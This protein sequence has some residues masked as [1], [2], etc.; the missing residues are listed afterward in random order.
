MQSLGNLQAQ[1]SEFE[2]A[3]LSYF[4]AIAAFNSALLLAPDYNYA[5]HNKGNTLKNLGDLQT[6]L[7]EEQEAL[8]N[9]QEALEMFNRYL[10]IAPND[11]SV[12]NMRD[13]L[14]EYF[15]N[16]GEDTVSS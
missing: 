8:K 4:D 1:L 2:S 10:A 14:Q 6:K 5:L 7:S 12:R 13:A 9:W 11:D 16:L 15:D 3:K